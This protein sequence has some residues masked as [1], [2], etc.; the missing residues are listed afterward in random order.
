M[1]ISSNLVWKRFASKRVCPLAK[2][3]LMCLM[4]WSFCWRPSFCLTLSTESHRLRWDHVT[5]SRRCGRH[6]GHPR[7]LPSSPDSHGST[8][9][10]WSYSLWC[11]FG[12]LCPCFVCVEILVLS[13]N[14]YYHHATNDW[15]FTLHISQT[16]SVGFIADQA[17]EHWISEYCSRIWRACVSV[18]MGFLAGWCE[19]LPVELKMDLYLWICVFSSSA[20]IPESVYSYMNLFLFRACIGWVK[21]YGNLFLPQSKKR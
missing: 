19:Y 1:S 2:L 18:F 12:S 7:C 9:T 10:Q 8:L 4:S 11:R 13:T 5:L 17:L 21:T 3:D 16:G 20:Y 14:K 6:T 15:S